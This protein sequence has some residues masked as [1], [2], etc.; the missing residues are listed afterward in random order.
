MDKRQLATRLN[1]SV[2]LVEKRCAARQWPFH[3]VARSYRFTEQDVA[4]I[5]ALV[6][7][8]PT[9]RPA[10]VRTK[11]RTTPV[12]EATRKRLRPRGH[13]LRSVS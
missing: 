2:S 8:P 9:A 11:V 1:V 4:Q 5:L 7:E 13:K 6:A 3:R 10:R 12:T